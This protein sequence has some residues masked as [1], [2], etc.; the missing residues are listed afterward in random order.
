MTDRY[1][2]LFD[3]DDDF[4]LGRGGWEEDLAEEEEE[5]DFDLEE[6]VDLAEAED[7]EGGREFELYS[8][9]VGVPL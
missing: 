8:T 7:A 4:G 6:E 1:C 9:R 5:A 3:D 2:L